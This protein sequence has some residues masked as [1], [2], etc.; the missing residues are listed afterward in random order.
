MTNLTGASL[1]ERMLTPLLYH[2]FNV[3]N[4]GKITGITNVSIDFVYS[5]ITGLGTGYWSKRGNRYSH[6]I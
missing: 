1:M 3:D 4:Q 2:N 6:H 5:I